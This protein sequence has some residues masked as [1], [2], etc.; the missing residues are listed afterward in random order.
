MKLTS[1][2]E[3]G[4]VDDTKAFAHAIGAP[5]LLA[6]GAALALSRPGARAGLSVRPGEDRHSVGPGA[7]P[8]V[9][10]RILADQL[11]RLWGQQVIVHQPAGRGRRGR[12]PRGGAA[13]R[14]RPHALHVACHPTTSRCRSCRAISRSTWCAISCRSASSASI[15]W[16]S[17][18]SADL[19]VNTLPELIALAKKRKG[20][21]NVAA[22]NRGSIL[23]LTGE[24]LRSATGI[25][26]TL[27]HYAAAPQAITDMLGGRVQAMIDAVTAMR[28][29]IDGGK[30]KPLAVA[31]QQARSRIPGPADGGRNHPGLRGD[32]LARADGAARHA[33]AAGAAGSA[34]TCARCWPSPSCRSATRSSAPTSARP[35]P[36]ELT[37]FIREQQQIWRPVIAETAKAI[38]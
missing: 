20:E 21:L 11:T 9:L 22:G 23:H 27:L 6:G 12:D 19:G 28:G 14:R 8:D 17:R 15:R 7:A 5:S 36:S 37:A 31:T 26:V 30:L 16:W 18:R 1:R 13:P 35:R 34:T 38:R 29:A 10:S 33:R 2:A 32:G 24:W 3:Q 25:D 4:R